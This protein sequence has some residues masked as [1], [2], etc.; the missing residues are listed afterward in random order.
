V[1]ALTMREI[2]QLDDW[3]RLR[4]LLR[5]M[6][7][8]EKDRRRLAVGEHVTLLFENAQT[9]WYQIEEMIRVER[10]VD[11]FAIQHE[12]DTYNQLLPKAAEL[13]ASLFIEY[14][15]A[16]ERDAALRRLVGLEKHFWLRVGQQRVPAV[17]D[18]A[19]IG[20]AQV[21]AVQFVRFPIP[22]AT[23]DE[24]LAAALAGEVAIEIDHPAMSVSAPI[25]GELARALADDAYELTPST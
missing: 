25:T 11:P 5:P 23:R 6:L 10:L 9:V 21:S 17:F 12:V 8:R 15:E 24:W 22:V 16:A 2:L 19:Q 18:A 20:E 7:V 1:K 14:A 13:S 3:E 4:S